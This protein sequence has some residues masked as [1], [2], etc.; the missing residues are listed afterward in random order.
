MRADHSKNNWDPMLNSGNL[1]EGMVD[2]VRQMRKYRE[3]YGEKE[4][5]S[6]KYAGEESWLV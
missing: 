4:K 6:V 3:N 2:K 5:M 1:L